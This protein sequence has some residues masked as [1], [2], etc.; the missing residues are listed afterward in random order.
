MRHIDYGLSVFSRE[1]FCDVL[2][3]VALDL[4][5]VYT[6]LTKKRALAAFEVAEC[7]YEIGS[8][9]GAEEL[10]KLLSEQGKDEL[11]TRP[12]RGIGS[13]PPENQY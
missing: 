10:T 9:S 8:F 4:A 1:V 2:P 11:C 7:F 12:S 3:G 6:D 13:N 5:S